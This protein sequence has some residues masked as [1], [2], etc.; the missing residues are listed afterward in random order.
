ME[1]AGEEHDDDRDPY[2]YEREEDPPSLGIHVRGVGQ[3]HRDEDR[4]GNR[5][6]IKGVVHVAVM[7]PNPIVENTVTVKYSSSVCVSRPPKLLAEIAA[8]TT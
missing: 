8:M 1:Q 3:V 7:P 6:A 4:S 5:R 2:T